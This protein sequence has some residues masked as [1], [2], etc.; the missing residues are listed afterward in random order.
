MSSPFPSLPLY[1]PIPPKNI[2]DSMAVEMLYQW[3]LTC[4]GFDV[5]YTYFIVQQNLCK[6]LVGPS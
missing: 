3:N 6:H 2:L 1:M 4:E 5:L